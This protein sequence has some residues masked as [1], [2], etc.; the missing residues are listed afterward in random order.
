MLVASYVVSVLAILVMAVNVYQ[1]VALRR[2]MVGGEIG[3]KWNALTWIVAVFL[4]GYLVAPLAVWYG[5]PHDDL[6]PVVFVVF[7][8]GA[9]FVWVVIGI[10]RDTLAFLK[11]TR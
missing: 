1:A 9:V 8:L 11:L 10:I 6:L 5:M 3:T 2:S 4:V 7:L